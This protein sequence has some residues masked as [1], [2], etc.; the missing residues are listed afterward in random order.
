MSHH[1]ELLKI[2]PIT[3]NIYISGIFPLYSDEDKIIKSEGIT[4]IL[5][6]V[7]RSRVSDAHNNIIASHPGVTI[8]YIPYDDNVTQNL[9]NKN[10]NHTQ[11]IKNAQDVSEHQH[12]VEQLKL[13][14]NKPMIEIAYHFIDNAVSSGNKVLVHCMAGVSRSVSTV[15]YYLMK[16]YNINFF[17]AFNYIQSKRS[18]ANPNN[19]FRYQLIM[20][21]RIGDQFNKSHADQIINTIQEQ[22]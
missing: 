3:D 5:S 18:I 8:L 2:S 19:S 11:L 1:N 21:N 10:R 17:Y 22:A 20:Y 12:I 16:K 14:N 13:Y 15:T 6:C 4:H 9:W 7:E